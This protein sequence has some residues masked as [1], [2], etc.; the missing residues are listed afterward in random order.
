MLESELGLFR[1]DIGFELSTW[2]SARYF[3]IAAVPWIWG[4]KLVIE[5]R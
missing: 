5:T 1:R 2:M 3:L 4:S